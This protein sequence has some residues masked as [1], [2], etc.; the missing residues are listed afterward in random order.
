MA[1]LIW[2]GSLLVFLYL[3]TPKVQLPGAGTDSTQGDPATEATGQKSA[4][5]RK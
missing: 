1:L 2:L 3:A 5:T 4:E